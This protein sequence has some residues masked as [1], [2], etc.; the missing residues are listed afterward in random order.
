MALDVL[1]SPG[2]RG[3]A[4]DYLDRS[5]GPDDVLIDTGAIF[6]ALT[7]SSG[8]P[9]SRP[10]VL[11]LAV[12]LR[13]TAIRF[14]RENNLNGIVRTGNGSRSGITKLQLEAGG[15]VKVL[16]LDRDEVCKR[17]QALVTGA[18]RVAACETGL[19]RF[20]GRYVPEDTDEVVK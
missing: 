18:D 1:V 6:T 14:A 15:S 5:L 12:G 9:S 11:A 10:A 20:Y 4:D 8:I 3:V 16:Q 7:G 2:C 13:T 19:D 17:I